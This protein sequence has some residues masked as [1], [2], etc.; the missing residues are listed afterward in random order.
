M[1]AFSEDKQAVNL[2]VDTNCLFIKDPNNADTIQKYSK[3]L[4]ALLEDPYISNVIAKT[5]EFI[6]SFQQSFIKISQLTLITKLI[7]STPT[8]N[9]FKKL[10]LSD[11][12]AFDAW[13]KKTKKPHSSIAF[14]NLFIWKNTSPIWWKGERAYAP[15]LI[16]LI[17]NNSSYLDFNA[18]KKFPDYIYLTKG[19]IDLQGNKYKHKRS[20]YNHFT[21][22]YKFQ[23]LPYKPAMKNDCLKLFSKWAK[24][25]KTKFNDP[26]YCGMIKDSFTAH[27]TAIEN[28][29]KLGLIGRV[30]KIKGKLSAYTFGFEL[31]KD[32]FCILLEVCDLKYKGISE[33]IF[34]EFCKELAGYKY[35]NTMD[36][37]G[38]ENLRQAK[39]SYHP[40]TDVS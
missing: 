10:S 5:P 13:I 18:Y 22:H 2:Y 24:E 29:K 16:L 4:L 14:V 31:T 40:I 30:I 27:K 25:R 32:T 26:Y 12:P 1:I 7:V 23:Y 33:F 35:I 19:L 20:A 39:L 6:G 37:S 34:R 8:K 17:E 36:D 11:K 21:K 38:L 3:Y 28:Y 15:Q 9:G